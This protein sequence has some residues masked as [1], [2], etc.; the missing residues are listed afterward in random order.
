MRV[1]IFNTNE[2]FLLKEINS[3]KDVNE[4]IEDI[5]KDYAIDTY[6]YKKVDNTLFVYIFIK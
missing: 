4:T 5:K 3:N 6:S 2:P 1:L